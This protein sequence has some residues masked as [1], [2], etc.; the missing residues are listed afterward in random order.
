MPP[1]EAIL[2]AFITLLVTVDPPGLVPLFLVLTAGMN[3]QERNQVA[4]R[5]SLI[6]FGIFMLFALAGSTILTALG[7]TLPA[8]RVAGGLLLFVIAFEMIFE[9][10]QERHERSAERAITR[11]LIDNIAAFPLAMPLIAGPGAISATVLL[12]GSFA[13]TEGRLV[14]V[15]ILAAT[16]LITY[17]VF[18]LAHRI[19]RILGETGRSILT[20]LL[21][22]LLAALAVQFVADGARALVNA[23]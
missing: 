4:I 9:H 15:A 20:R 18:V 3:K 6:S 23:G 13:T 22:L 19:D 5:A 12:S 10:R 7:I 2:S 11:D 8:F 14:L 21:G 16:I 17:V 1:H